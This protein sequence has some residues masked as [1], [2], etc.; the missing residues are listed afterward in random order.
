ME[1]KFI[2]NALDVMKFDIGDSE[3]DLVQFVNMREYSVVTTE[4]PLLLTIGLQSCIALF[5]YEKNFSFLSHMNIITCEPDFL[6]NEQ[7]EPIRCNR[8]DNL[9][10]EIKKNQDRIKNTINIGLILG[11]TPVGKDHKSRVVIEKD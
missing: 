2:R 7:K 5:A 6:I 8:I 9:Y 3:R 4:K 1:N 10:E 11:V